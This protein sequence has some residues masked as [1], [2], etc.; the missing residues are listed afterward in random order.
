MAGF[1]P[2][3]LWGGDV[4]DG[5]LNVRESRLGGVAPVYAEGLV[6][7]GSLVHF[8]GAVGAG[9]PMEEATGFL[10]GRKVAAIGEPGRSYCL[11]FSDGASLLG[12]ASSP[13]VASLKE[14]IRQVGEGLFMDVFSRADLIVL[15]GASGLDVLAGWGFGLL[16]KVLPNTFPRDRRH[17]LIDLAH[18]GMH[19]G[20]NLS[21]VLE[22]AAQ[23]H[24]HGETTL[25]FSRETLSAAANALETGAAGNWERELAH[26]H[27]RLGVRACLLFGETTPCA[28]ATREGVHSCSSNMTLSGGFLCPA[29]RSFFTA[30][31]AATLAGISQKCRLP[32]AVAAA[33]YRFLNKIPPSW[34]EIDAYIRQK[35]SE[36]G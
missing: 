18:V 13:K 16:E 29:P 36:N 15:S 8:Y 23:L 20:A 3:A 21:S 33:E 24:S 32:L 10:T 27:D 34:V 12:V 31:S 9:E 14:V 26:V 2:C 22:V 6:A 11:E 4:A 1:G 30:Y 5:T 25:G 7:L 17:F 35:L 28:V 19:S